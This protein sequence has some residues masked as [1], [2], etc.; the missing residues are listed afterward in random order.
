MA[1]LISLKDAALSGSSMGRAAAAAGGG[2]L[3]GSTSSSRNHPAS[4]LSG[5]GGGD[6]GGSAGGRAFLAP[7]P[8]P[9]LAAVAPRGAGPSVRAPEDVP[10]SPGTVGRR[11]ASRL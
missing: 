3:T 1:S 6:S 8:A 2:L 10:E 11:G 5:A 4:S 7:S 9:F